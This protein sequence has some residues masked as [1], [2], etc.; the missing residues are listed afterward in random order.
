MHSTNLCKTART[1]SLKLLD[2]LMSAKSSCETTDRQLFSSCKSRPR[3]DLP[4]R[5][6][7]KRFTIE[8]RRFV[9]DILL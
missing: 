3:F 4:C 5:S 9:R 6:A 7:E 1:I 8:E 2:E